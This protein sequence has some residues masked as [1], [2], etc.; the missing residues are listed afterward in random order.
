MR[1]FWRN[2]GAAG[3]FVV[4]VAVVLLATGWG[5]AVASSLTKVLVTNTPDKPIP[6]TA[7][8]TVP[9]AVQNLPASQTVNGSVSV[10]NFPSTQT[11]GGSVSV[12]NFPSTQTVAGSVSV[13]NF[14]ST[15]T[16]AGAVQSSDVTRFL[17]GSYAL[18]GSGTLRLVDGAD[19][20]SA[21]SVRLDVTCSGDPGCPGVT[22]TV[23][24]DGTMID[25]F[26]IGNS[27]A[28]GVNDDSATRTYEVPGQ[29]LYVDAHGVNP[30]MSF[31]AYVYGRSN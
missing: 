5:S 12:S 27:L 7:T 17:G 19:V 14:P 28:L 24:A 25:S 22:I 8:S 31:N 29:V 13:S 11:V 9:V 30:N 15:Q 2:V 20:S 21:R 16:V 4:V 6:V 26:T 23:V 18:Q 1:A 3:G 10:D